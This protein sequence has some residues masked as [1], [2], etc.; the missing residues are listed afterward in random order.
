MSQTMPLRLRAATKDDFAALAGR[1][2]DPRYHETWCGYSLEHGGTVI[3]IGWFSH[4]CGRTWAW[5]EIV[6]GIP[7]LSGITLTRL[8]RA[9]LADLKA[10]G[11]KAVHCYRNETIPHSDRWLRLLGFREAPEI[12]CERMVWRCDL[13]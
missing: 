5:L 8:V 9:E 11:V 6:P 13:I 2:P 3:G 12:E 10:R 1:Q 7:P 4:G